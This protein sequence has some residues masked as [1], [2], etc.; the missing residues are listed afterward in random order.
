MVD[1][2]QGVEAQ[3]LANV[4]LA[5][6]NDLEIVPAINKV[7]LPS[8]DVERAKEEIENFIGLDTSAAVPTRAKLALGLRTFWRLSWRIC[9][10]LKATLKPHC[11][12]C[13]LIRGS[14]PTGESS[15]W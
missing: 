2:T 14:I 5:I 10:R 6:D 4:Y 11:K 7:D 9:H 12:R 15:V 13:S 1:A 8:A 3:T